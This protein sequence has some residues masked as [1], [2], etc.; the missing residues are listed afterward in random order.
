MAKLSFKK[1]DINNLIKLIKEQDQT[2]LQDDTLVVSPEEI[3]KILPAI[4]Y[5]IKALSRIK[6]Y[7][8]KK[9]IIDGDF[10]IEGKP[11]KSLGPII[12]ILGNLDISK[13]DVASI[14]GVE[15]KGRVSDWNSERSR[16]RERKRVAGLRA[17][18]QSRREDDDWNIEKGDSEG[19]AAQAIFEYL[20]ENNENV[21]TEEDVENLRGLKERLGNLYYD[22]E[23]G[24]DSDELQDQIDSLEAEIEE[25]EEKID[26]YELIPSSYRFYGDLYRFEIYSGDLKGA[27]YAAGLDS[28]A[29]D[30]AL[31]YAKEYI[32]EVGVEGFSRGFYLD[33]LD[34]DG[35]V[36][37]FRDFYENDIRD[38][39]ES[40]FD[41]SDYELTEEQEKRKEQ[42]ESYIEEMEELLSD[43]EQEQRDLED[44][45]SDEYYELD[46]K[47]KEIESNIETAQ[48]ELD[49]I[50]PDTEPTEEMIEDKVK[51]YLR[52]VRYDPADKL[53]EFGMDISEWVDKND[54]AQ[55]L[56]DSD[57]YGIMN[58]YD[59]NYSSVYVDGKEYIVMRLN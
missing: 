56:V 25:I 9:I 28:D 51:D 3:Y 17:E 6:K 43:T 26:V 13:S 7:K 37:Y 36:E 48:N 42:L 33:Y 23:Q 2:N 14:E 12:K 29:E 38:N 45:D 52:D 53:T 5:N 21:Q 20:Q 1:Q 31:E 8:D 40:Y 50:V 19:L 39:P 55:G 58:G 35:I 49:S 46:E 22:Q 24:N 10:S 27:E 47:I 11:V 34:V 4:D 18:A 32:D 16:I 59:G 57:G 54:L 41:E 30:A 15:V 44:S